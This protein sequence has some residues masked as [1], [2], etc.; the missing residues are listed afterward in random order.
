M[1]SSC[2]K[3]ISP[4]NSTILVREITK[5][6]TSVIQCRMSNHD[7]LPP[8]SYLK[9]EGSSTPKTP[10]AAATASTL[11]EDDEWEDESSSTNGGNDSAIKMT[12]QSPRPKAVR[13]TPI[14]VSRTGTSSPRSRTNTSPRNRRSAPSSSTIPET[15]PRPSRPVVSKTTPTW[16]SSLGWT[17]SVALETLIA[18]IRLFHVIFSPFYPYVAVGLGILL[19]LSTTLHL[20]LDTVPPLIFRVPGHLLRLVMPSL[21]SFAWSR[22][23]GNDDTAIGQGLALLPLRSL[24]T[25]LCAL[26]GQVCSLSLMTR[27][28]S[29]DDGRQRVNEA[30]PFWKWRWTF[31][32]EVD[33]GQVARSL[34]KEAKGAKGIFDSVSKL[35]DGR[36]MGLDYV[37]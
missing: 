31:T 7:P 26:T 23:T 34:A 2:R 20:L 21:P 24:A 14:K 6:R 1:A 4:P 3:P 13:R 28:T 32:P 5:A 18:L 15:P 27:M 30:E 12:E 22:F 25:P 17:F 11:S 36:L 29:A 9:G 19:A 8:G 33:V 35:S 37:R 10:H 16:G